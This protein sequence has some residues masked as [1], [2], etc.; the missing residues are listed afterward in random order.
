MLDCGDDLL[1]IARPILRKKKKKW[2]N[3]HLERG[4]TNVL[5]FFKNDFLDHPLKESTVRTGRPTMKKKLN[6]DISLESQ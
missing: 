3:E 5:Q 6:S 1:Y 2:Q 4:V